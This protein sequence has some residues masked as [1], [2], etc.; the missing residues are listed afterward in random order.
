[1]GVRGALSA[2][3][4]GRARALLARP[5]LSGSPTRRLS[6]R[7]SPPPRRERPEDRERRSPRARLAARGRPAEVAGAL[8]D[9][10]AALPGPAGRGAALGA[11]RRDRPRVRP[12]PRAAVA[13][14]LADRSRM[15]AAR[16][17]RPL[18]EDR[19]GGALRSEVAGPEESAHPLRGDQPPGPGRSP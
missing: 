8:R 2:Q 9:G 18:L 15:A 3:P 10:K 14:P 6:G 4:L 19:P 7:R 12:G 5:P 16:A 13:A 17:R 11:G 1:R